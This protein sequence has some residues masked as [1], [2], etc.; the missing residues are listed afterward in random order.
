MVWTRFP[1]DSTFL[2]WD[3]YGVLYHSDVLNKTLEAH[4]PIYGYLT[5]GYRSNDVRALEYV[6][7]GL[8]TA[9]AVVFEPLGVHMQTWAAQLLLLSFFA[10]FSYTHPYDIK[11][12]KA[13]VASARDGHIDSTLWHGSL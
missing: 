1:H 2:N 8:F 6:R 9:F 13:R 11:F 5:S 4:R 10:V 12:V 3:S 7:K